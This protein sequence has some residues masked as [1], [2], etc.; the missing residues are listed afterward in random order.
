MA[1]LR[2]KNAIFFIV[3]SLLFTWIAQVKCGCT[4]E[5]NR[6]FIFIMIIVYFFLLL[7]HSELL[8][9]EQNKY[10]KDLFSK[11]KTAVISKQWLH[12]HMNGYLL[13]T[14]ATKAFLW[15]LQYF[16]LA[17][18]RFCVILRVVRCVFSLNG[19]KPLDLKVKW[20]LSHL[21]MCHGTMLSQCYSCGIQE[22]IIYNN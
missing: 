17:S 19:W 14:F 1:T 12:L 8:S 13:K 11:Q 4:V 9:A 18:K 22:N 15:S 21:Q 5:R 16:Q 2:H 3:A 6:L 10:R 20:H 7:C